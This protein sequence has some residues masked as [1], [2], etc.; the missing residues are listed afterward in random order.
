MDALV[1][2]NVSVAYKKNYAVENVSFNVPERQIS[3]LIGLNG[4]GKTSMI[5]VLLGLRLPESGRILLYGQN[6]DDQLSRQ[7]I[8][9]LP[10]RFDPPGFLT[11]AEFLKFYTQ[12]RKESYD[13]A[14]VEEYASLL[15]FNIADLSKRMSFY[16]KGMRQKIGLIS[17]FVSNADLLILDE[18]MSGLDPLARMRVR[19]ALKMAQE[20]GKT[21]FFSS[22]ILNDMDE[23]CHHI[24]VVDQKKI[25]FVGTP[26]EMT[27]ANSEKNLEHSFLKMIKVA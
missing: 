9:F 23:I 12:F 5:K 15:N 20:K 14:V 25:Q 24:I 19:S 13:Q 22:H 7:R 26:A 10:E 8:A 6:I 27:H 1:F 2:D 17:M 21:V 3:G 4:A 11:G 16:S 18:P